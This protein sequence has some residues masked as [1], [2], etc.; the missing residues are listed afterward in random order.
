MSP[1]STRVL[2]VED[3]DPTRELYR[4]A[5][6]RNGYLVVA[7]ADGLAALRAIESERPDVIVLDL[8]L[9][10]LA[11]RDVLR[12]VRENPLTSAIPVIVVT[13]NSSVDLHE[14]I[15]TPILTKPVDT[16]ALISAIEGVRRRVPQV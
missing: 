3:D 7:V 16:D 14:P 4:A 13:G 1:L 11:G 12:E 2:V 15:P 9:P 8:A 10:R 5:L 6:K